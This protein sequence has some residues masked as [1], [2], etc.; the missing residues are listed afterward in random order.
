MTAPARAGSPA[1]AGAVNP[2]RRS[3]AR[4][5]RVFPLAATATVFIVHSVSIHSQIEAPGKLLELSREECLAHLAAEAFGR[6][7]ATGSH[8][9]PVVRPI[10]YRFDPAS[11]SIMFQTGRG[12]KL[13]ALLHEHMAVFE[14]DGIDPITR[15]GWSVLVSGAAEPIVHG[16][17]LARVSR[18]GPVSWVGGEGEAMWMRI[19]IG[20][21][22]GRRICGAIGN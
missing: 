16:P 17:E 3:P 5:L 7:A 12:S 10:N 13:H 1:G 14:I 18:R 22:S 11:Q 9:V 8:G 6:L 20:T 15:T 4:G 2:P 21:V 19:R